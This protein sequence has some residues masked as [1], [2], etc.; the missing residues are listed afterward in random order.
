MATKA[1]LEASLEKLDVEVPE[2]ATKEELE[3]LLK[4]RTKKAEKAE[5]EAT[6]EPEVEAETEEEEGEEEKEPEEE[7]KNYKGRLGGNALISVKSER[8]IGVAY[9][10]IWLEDGT[11]MVLSEKDLKKQLKTK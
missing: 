7:V 6:P 9:K 2:K 4:K 3:K 1:Q 11:T 5:L 10:R 8:I